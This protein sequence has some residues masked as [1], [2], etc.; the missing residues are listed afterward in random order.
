MDDIDRNSVCGKCEKRLPDEKETNQILVARRTVGQKVLERHARE[1]EF[2]FCICLGFQS[3]KPASIRDALESKESED[4]LSYEDRRGFQVIERSVGPDP[5]IDRAPWYDDDLATQLVL[6]SQ[7]PPEQFD[8]IYELVCK[9]WRGVEPMGEKV[10]K[11]MERLRKK[12][13]LV[14]A[15]NREGKWY[16]IDNESSFPVFDAVRRVYLKTLECTG[17]LLTYNSWKFLKRK[18]SKRSK[19]N[20][21]PSGMGRIVKN[22]DATLERARRSPH[23]F[24]FMSSL[25]NPPLRSLLSNGRCLFSPGYFFYVFSMSAGQQNRRVDPAL[26][27]LTLLLL[28]TIIFIPIYKLCAHFAEHRF[29]NSQV[30]RLLDPHPQS[31]VLLLLQHKALPPIRFREALLPA[32]LAGTIICI[33]W[34]CCTWAAMLVYSLSQKL[35]ETDPTL[36]QKLQ[37]WFRALLS[38]S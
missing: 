26:W 8:R 12:G 2:D 37:S 20:L 28:T 1:R 14:F 23:D 9:H 19:M 13:E 32:F 33:L 22:L 3:D 30:F 25:A 7:Y 10:R 4:G 17:H 18:R 35:P 5:R 36:R 27:P 31:L 15:K 34:A 38:G 16:F 11:D 6:Y 29:P 24:P 21:T